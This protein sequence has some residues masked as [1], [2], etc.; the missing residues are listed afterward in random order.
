MIVPLK[1]KDGTVSAYV[2]LTPSSSFRLLRDMMRTGQKLTD[3]SLLEFR[4]QRR[5]EFKTRPIDELPIELQM[6]RRPFNPEKPDFKER[7]RMTPEQIIALIKEKSDWLDLSLSIEA[8]E[9]VFGKKFWVD[10]G[11][12][13]HDVSK[14]W[15]IDIQEA[16]QKIGL[17]AFEI[18]SDND[19]LWGSI[20]ESERASA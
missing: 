1:W 5:V 11:N 12:E 15:S 3:F 10:E 14:Q 4:P 9:V 8:G 6:L 16:L 7:K 20:R 2:E 13:A 17:E 19:S 18:E